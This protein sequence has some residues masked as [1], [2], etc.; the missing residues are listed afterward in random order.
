MFLCGEGLRG[1]FFSRTGMSSRCRQAREMVAPS[2]KEDGDGG[3]GSDDGGAGSDE[4][5][6]GSER[7]RD[8][9][10]DGAKTRGPLGGKKRDWLLLVAL[11][12]EGRTD[13]HLSQKEEGWSCPQKDHHWNL[14]ARH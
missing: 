14:E 5:G 7:V 11:A 3:A 8:E 4:G 12:G 9:A 1:L 13:H 2:Q 6:A 10:W